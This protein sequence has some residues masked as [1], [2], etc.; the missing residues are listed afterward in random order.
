MRNVRHL[1]ESKG[2][3]VYSV[4]PDAPVVEAIRLMAQRGIGAL[5][6]LDGERL[7]GVVSERDYARKVV[8]QGRSS[9]ST[10]VQEIMT[11]DVVQVG[12]DDTVDRCM[13]L[14]T[15]RRLRHLPVVD[16]D[17]VIGVVS[18]GDLVKA[19]IEDQQEELDQLQR[20]IAG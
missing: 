20:Y 6:V 2:S 7:A 4:A 1:L 14:V 19:V 5:V 3:E 10:L 17:R 8:L 11:P 12:L 9:S 18:I 13:Q 16:G 15:D